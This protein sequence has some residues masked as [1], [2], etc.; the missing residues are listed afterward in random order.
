MANHDSVPPARHSLIRTALLA[1]LAFYFADVIIDVLVFRKGTLIDQLL[2]PGYH[3]LWMRAGIFILIVAFAIYIQ[4]L[5]RRAQEA[6][7]RTRTAEIFLNSVF[8]NIPGM[9][10]IKDAREL[11]F[12]RVNRTGEKLLGL[13]TRE[14]LGRNDYD[15]FPEAQAEFFTRKDRE[16]LESGV[17]VNIPEEEID[18][19]TMGKRWL[20]TRKV[21][22]LDD[23][24]RPIYLLGI[25]EDITEARQ[26]EEEIQRQRSEMAHVIR[27]TTMGELAAGLAHE[28]N[29][30]LAA[31]TSY[32]G[33]AS[34]L[35]GSLPSPSPQLREVLVHAEEQAQRA[36]QIIRQLR[37]FLSKGDGHKE[38]LD[39]DQV[40][41]GTIEII[42]PELKNTGATLEH[43]PGARAGKVMAS[44]VQLEQVLV[45]LLLNSLEALKG[46]DI[47]DGKIIVQTRL[48]PDA[49]LETTVTD[50]GPGVDADMAGRMFH[51][52]QTTKPAGLGMGLSISSSIIEAHGG[53]MWADLQRRDGALFGFS[54]PVCDQARAR[55]GNNLSVE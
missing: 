41:A 29:Q 35:A 40:I 11:R 18:T 54:L 32:C 49:T 19:V 39:L 22:I 47:P 30:P 20:H 8:D 52:F 55:Q 28:L 31:L 36:G 45:N 42:K 10:F 44:K 9:V 37:D 33:A 7:G 5:I 13:S 26:A 12:V 16:V 14:L 2:N 27:L 25:S 48:L 51:P 50:N 3:E 15:F 6:S 23:D 17:E 1:G 38:L 46:Q 21:P 4:M 34:A 53:R 43:V 24:G